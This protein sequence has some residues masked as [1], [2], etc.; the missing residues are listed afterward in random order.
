[1]V[2]KP[3]LTDWAAGYG[4]LLMESIRR[5]GGAGGYHH[6]GSLFSAHF[7]QGSP[8]SRQCGPRRGVL[9]SL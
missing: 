8:H 1:M 5:S 9:Q 3:F 7:T 2:N 6:G 4:P